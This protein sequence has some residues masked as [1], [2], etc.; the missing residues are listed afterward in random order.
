MPAD[1]IKGV[2]DKGTKAGQKFLDPNEFNFEQHRW[3][4]FLVLMSQLEKNVA[5]L[6]KA[7]GTPPDSSLTKL[8]Q[9]E[10]AS[11][12]NESARYPYYRDDE[13][14]G[15]AIPRINALCDLM[16]CWHQINSK[17]NV[18]EFFG[19]DAPQPDPV[20]RVTPGI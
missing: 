17:E 12:Q 7:F 15:K 2:V 13:W 19:Q 18:T 3:V 8:V 6:Q 10:L 9:Q 1:T 20:L 4:R 14:C 11:G 5:Y 16:S